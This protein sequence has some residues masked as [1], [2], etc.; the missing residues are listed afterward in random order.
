MSLKQLERKLLKDSGT[1]DIV[2]KKGV[3]QDE[4]KILTPE[5]I[6]HDVSVLARMLINVYV[7]WPS[8]SDT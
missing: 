7:G 4:N 2:E 5:D 1:D 3:P 8:L 6:Q